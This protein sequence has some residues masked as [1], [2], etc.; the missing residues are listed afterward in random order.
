MT[1]PAQGNAL[2]YMM[3]RTF[4]LKGQNKFTRRGVFCDALSG[5]MFMTN[6]SQGVAL[7]QRVLGFQPSTA[8]ASLIQVPL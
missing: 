5:R 2:G 8:V 3:Q 6:F 4:A 1:S 7:G